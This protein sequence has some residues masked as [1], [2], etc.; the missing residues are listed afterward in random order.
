MAGN[1]FAIASDTGVSVN[2]ILD[3]LIPP[4]LS[5]FEHVFLP[6]HWWPSYECCEMF[7]RCWAGIVKLGNHR[8]WENRSGKRTQ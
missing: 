6:T 4:S 2:R 5:A 8:W 3:Q 1:L 7:V